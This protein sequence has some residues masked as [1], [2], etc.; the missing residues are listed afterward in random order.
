MPAQDDTQRSLKAQATA[1]AVDLGQVRSLLQAQSIPSISQPVL[2]VVICWL[3]VLFATF[4]LMAPPNATAA[5][6]LIASAVSVAIT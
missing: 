6:A 3:V 5:T 2:T 1:V 4:S